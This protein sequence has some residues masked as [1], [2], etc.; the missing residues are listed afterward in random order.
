[1]PPVPVNL[2]GWLKRSFALRGWIFER[3]TMREN[4]TENPLLRALDAAPWR[5]IHTRLT[6]A[7]AAAWLLDAFEVKIIGSIIPTITEQWG[8]SGLQGVSLVAV[9]LLGIMVGAQGAGILADRFGR[10]RLFLLTLLFYAGFT[11]LCAFSVN[12]EML[13]VL[14]FLTAI[15][16]GAE[17]SVINAA[18]SEFIPARYRGRAN[19]GVMSA[20]GIGALLAAGLGGVVLSYFPAEL[21]WRVGFGVGAV[22][23]LMAVF[24][25]RALPESPRWLLRRGD[26]EEARRVV[27]EVA[28]T[29]PP[30]AEAK[31][32]GGRATESA[33][34]LGSLFR[35]APRRTA[36]G[37]SLDFAEAAGYYGLFAMFT[38]LVVPVVGI[39]AT[40]VTTYLF[41]GGAGALVGGLL[42]AAVMDRFPR[43]LVVTTTYA[44]AAASM[45]TMTVATATGNPGAV[46]WAFVFANLAG[47]AAWVSAYPTFTE[48][49][50]THLRASGVGFSVLVGRVGAAVS[51]IGLAAIAAAFSLT[52]AFTLLAGFWLI[53]VAAMLLWARGGPEGAN[54]SLERLEPRLGGGAA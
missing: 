5:P 34:S 54:A 12:F 21:G 39:S 10:R 19:A 53:G 7:L 27:R 44:V 29:S 24:A 31:T 46:F 15:G 2:G 32:G 23:A 4:L 22:M 43:V 18:I 41:W 37:A 28:G 40:G 1:M 45:I 25:R 16:V 11:F 20:W 49:F 26:E 13:M 36:L 9:W 50:P 47:T 3:R 8:L 6:V 33:G 51:S 35:Q 38:A 17:Y 14:R 30:A 48:L 42:V 52:V